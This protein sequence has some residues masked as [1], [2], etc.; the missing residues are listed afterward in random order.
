[1][2][3]GIRPSAFPF[4]SEQYFR[5]NKKDPRDPQTRPQSATVRGK[6]YQGA[7]PP[8]PIL[9]A[10]VLVSVPGARM[11]GALSHFFQVQTYYYGMNND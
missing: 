4:R 1:M 8:A 2:S 3:V 5:R 9:G 11:G 7:R 10:D 6:H